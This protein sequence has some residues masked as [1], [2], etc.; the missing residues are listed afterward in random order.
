MLVA[1]YLKEEG[2]ERTSSQLVSFLT[3]FPFTAPE[4]FF[5]FVLCFWIHPQP[6]VVPPRPEDFQHVILT[7]HGVIVE[8]LVALQMAISLLLGDL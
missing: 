3:S 6:P 8:F 7:E 4:Q 5:V 1:E 2:V